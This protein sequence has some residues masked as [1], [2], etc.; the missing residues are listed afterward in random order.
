MHIA[1]FFLHFLYAGLFFLIFK[2]FYVT[3]NRVMRSFQSKSYFIPLPPIVLFQITAKS[4]GK[5]A[6]LQRGK[7]LLPSIGSM[8][9]LKKWWNRNI[10]EG[11]KR[12][13]RMK[14][15]WQKLHYFKNYFKCLNCI[16]EFSCNE[17]SLRELATVSCPVAS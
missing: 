8:T 3:E 15:E 14:Y 16:V 4:C 6:I 7:N 17:L 1:C 10:K 2:Q 9:I 11:C 13:D 12:R 5:V